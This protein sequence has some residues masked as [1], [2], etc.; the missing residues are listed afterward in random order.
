MSRDTVTMSRYAFEELLKT[1][2]MIA[3]CDKTAGITHPGDGYAHALGR[4]NGAAK[5]MLAHL[6]YVEE[7]NQVKR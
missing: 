5:T 3:E 1:A 2:R 4:C 6:E 7:K